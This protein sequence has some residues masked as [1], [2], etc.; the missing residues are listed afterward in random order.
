METLIDIQH[1]IVKY[2]KGRYKIEET[3][4]SLQ[5]ARERLIEYIYADLN[6]PDMSGLQ[7][8]TEDLTPADY[9]NDSNGYWKN[10]K[11][12]FAT[13]ELK[14]GDIIFTEL[15][16]YTNVRSI[17]RSEDLQACNIDYHCVRD[18]VTYRVWPIDYAEQMTNRLR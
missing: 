16:D 10:V 11:D 12:K 8:T 18:D 4:D 2:Q 9:D 14:E 1:C 5:E 15:N 13:L 6:N 3:L 7:I 17:Y